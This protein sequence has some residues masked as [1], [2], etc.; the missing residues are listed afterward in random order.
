MMTG[1]GCAIGPVLGSGI[2]TLVGYEKTFYC[3]GLA[4]IILS[5]VICLLFPR[6]ADL[7]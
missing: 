2:F 4:N 5:A 1:F 6:K 7:F 3:F